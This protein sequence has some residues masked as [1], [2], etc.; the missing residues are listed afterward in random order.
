[1]FLPSR[2]DLF[3]SLSAAVAAP[4]M[5]AADVPAG[6][7]LLIR[8]GKIVDGTGNP[9]FQG[10]LAITGQRIAAIGR[11][12][13]IPAKRTIDATGLAVAPGFIDIHSHSDMLLLEDGKAEGKIRQGVTLEVFGE[14][15]SAG[16][17][18]GKM[19]PARF[20]DSSRSFQWTTLGGYFDALDKS[21]ISINAASY[22]GIDN[23]WRSVMGSSFERPTAAQFQEMQALVDEAMRDGAFGLSSMLAMPPGSLTTTDDIV[24]LCEPIKKY[25]GLFSTHNRNEGLGVLAAIKEAI[26]VGERAGVA[27]D[28]IHLKIAD[29]KLWGK[30]PE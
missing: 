18:K 26:A 1:M 9:W 11:A 22:V 27:V 6:C 24:K 4:W 2:R 21:G 23:V 17:A 5:T 25:G 7:D 3:A 14:G 12:L 28:V 20:R 16:P 30:M 15:Q 19:P 13:N 10:D 8:N 29:Q